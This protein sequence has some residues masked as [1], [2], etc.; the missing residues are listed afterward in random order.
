MTCKRILA[1]LLVFG[2]TL[3]SMP[4]YAAETSSD[5]ADLLLLHEEQIS[6]KQLDDLRS[7]AD[8]ATTLGESMD[9]AAVSETETF[10]PSEL[11]F[12][13]FSF[14]S[15]ASSSVLIPYPDASE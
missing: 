8:T 5:E 11:S 1:V 4:T 2:I 10:C 12:R 15:M 13:M 3:F 14:S 9:I 7:L 6:D